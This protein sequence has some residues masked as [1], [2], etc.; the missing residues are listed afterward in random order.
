M[1]KS[2]IRNLEII[3]LQEEGK[4]GQQKSQLRG[5]FFRCVKCNYITNVRARFT[6]HVKY[7]SMPMIK[8]DTCDFR[9][10]YKVRFN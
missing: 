7:H 5:K 8:C 10:P 6:K 1:I 3:I 9:T 4:E 2:F